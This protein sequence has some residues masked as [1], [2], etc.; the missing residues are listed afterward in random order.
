MTDSIFV[1]ERIICLFWFCSALLSALASSQRSRGGEI[2]RL[3]EWT[4]RD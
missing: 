2:V 3:P 4:L 1:G